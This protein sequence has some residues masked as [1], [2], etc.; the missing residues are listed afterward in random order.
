M[1]LI[2]GL[3]L[4]QYLYLVSDTRLTIRNENTV[5]Y[6]DNFCKFYSFNDSVSVVVAGSANLASFILNKLS[7]SGFVNNK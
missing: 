5:E 6:K 1:S 2:L 7:E 4:P 3:N